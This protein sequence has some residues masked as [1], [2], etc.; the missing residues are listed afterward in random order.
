MET[1]LRLTISFFVL[2]HE[3]SQT[4]RMYSLAKAG[5]GNETAGLDNG[6]KELLQLLRGLSC[7]VLAVLLFSWVIM[8]IR[9][10]DSKFG[11]QIPSSAQR[12]ELS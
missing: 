12:W 10:L 5:Y 2:D 9:I 7:G 6:M 4:G 11:I 1:G 8:R 3:E